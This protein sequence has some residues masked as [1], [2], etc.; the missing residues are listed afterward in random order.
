MEIPTIKGEARTA[1]GSR[2]AA[3]LRRSGRLPAVVYGHRQEPQAV[4]LSA[5]D[6]EVH[7]QHG[8]HL[9]NLELAGQV[10]PCLIK[11][12]QYD[13]LGS[14][15]M[16]V[17]LARVDLNEKVKVRV[18]IELRGTPRGIAEGGVLRQELADLE[19][20]CLVSRI[21]ERVRVD[22]SELGLHAVLYVKDLKL[23]EGL[24]AASDAES[25]VATVRP[26]HVM[27]EAPVSAPAEAAAAEPEVIA[28]G[29]AEEEG[30]EAP[31]KEKK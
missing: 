4:S 8:A 14:H 13:Y 29:K 6:M 2:A 23:E 17:D 7:L 18:T 30:A 11:E 26:P 25:V 12:A 31:E 28:R 16:H 21:P 19:V 1:A 20:E 22:V 15:L 24:T 3:R 5:H 9:L 27:A 10:Q